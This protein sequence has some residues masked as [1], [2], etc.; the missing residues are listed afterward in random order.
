MWAVLAFH[1]CARS[2]TS[3]RETEASPVAL[4]TAIFGAALQTIVNIVNGRRDVRV[5]PRPLNHTG[6]PVLATPRRLGF[7]PIAEPHMLARRAVIVSHRLN[8]TDALKD[9]GCP[10]ILVPHFPGKNVD[11]CPSIGFWSVAIG[12][13]TRTHSDSAS[14]LVVVHELDPRGRSTSGAVYIFA[15]EIPDRWKFAR[16]TS[17]YF[18]E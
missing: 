4:D 13:P 10:G 11:D 2:T 16:E 1:A 15:L 18:I 17:R 9:E 3:A 14:V 6:D 12:L 5:D 8:V 7:V